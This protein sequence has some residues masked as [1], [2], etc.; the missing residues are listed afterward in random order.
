MLFNLIWAVVVVVA[1]LDRYI[2]EVEGAAVAAVEGAKNRS[3]MWGEGIIISVSRR[4]C[5]RCSTIYV[6]LHSR[7]TTLYNIGDDEEHR[8]RILDRSVGQQ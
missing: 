7:D 4:R 3:H 6:Y 5:Q 2:I 8:R 1:R